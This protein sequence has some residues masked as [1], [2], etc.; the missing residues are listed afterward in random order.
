MASLETLLD[1]PNGTTPPGP[2]IPGHV[3][4]ENMIGNMA[5]TP[6]TPASFGPGTPPFALWIGG[7]NALV[8]GRR[9]LERFGKGMKLT[10]K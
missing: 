10:G 8:D 4:T 9:L 2:Q 5:M 6:E 1:F 3:M 7:S